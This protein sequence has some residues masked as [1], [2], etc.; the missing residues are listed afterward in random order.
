MSTPRGRCVGHNIR[1]VL[2]LLR[3]ELE[4]N[5]HVTRVVD[6]FARVRKGRHIVTYSR[7]PLTGHY[8]PLAMGTRGPV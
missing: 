3:D 5:V 2:G 7:V 8:P 4:E 1:R 6:L